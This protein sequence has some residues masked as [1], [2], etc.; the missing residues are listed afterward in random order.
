[1]EGSFIALTK[2][3]G[4]RRAGGTGPFIYEDYRDNHVICP[5]RESALE[6]FLGQTFKGMNH[7]RKNARSSNSEDALTWSCFDTLANVSENG[8]ATALEE[9]WELAYGDKAPPDGFEASRIQIGKTYGKDEKKTEVDLSFEGDRFVVLV[10]AKL[11]SPMGQADPNN[12]KPHNQIGRKLTIGLRAAQELG[13]DFYFILLDIAPPDCLA[14]L[15]PRASLKEARGKVS[16]FGGKWLTSYWFSRYKYGCRGSLSPL[17]EL[18]EKEGLD[19]DQVDQ[20]ADR[21]GWLTWA[22]VFKAV[23]RGAMAVR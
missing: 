4:S 3:H 16:G 19:A 17:R 8:R 10:E 12:Y 7:K 21:M 18:L 22:D 20:V 2:T 23:L 13:K 1:L 11:Y 14:L 9:L 5:G 15:K 6:D